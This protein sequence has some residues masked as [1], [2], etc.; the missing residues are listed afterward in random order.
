MTFR[1]HQKMSPPKKKCNKCGN[2][3]ALPGSADGLG[4]RCGT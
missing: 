2:E 1:N 3:L 4:E